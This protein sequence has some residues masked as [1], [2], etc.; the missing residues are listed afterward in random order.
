MAV[1][2][3]MPFAGGLV[4]YYCEHITPFEAQV[5]KR[6]C[7][8]QRYC[9]LT[10]IFKFISRLGDGPLWGALAVVLLVADLQAY[11][12][13][14]AAMALAIGLSVVIFMSVKNLVGRPRPFEAWDSLPCI[15]NPPDRFSFPSG[16]TMTAFAVVGVWVVLI[17]GYW[18]VLLPVAML[19]GLSRIY[20]G[21]H[22]PT[23]VLFG[24]LLGTTIG[25]FTARLFSICML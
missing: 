14:V 22:Y 18:F 5:M 10:A 7:V 2:R 21:V 3:K 6:F 11:K 1:S 25:M 23:D 19:I 9:W 20:L 8:L 16:H 24:A 13:V 17:P 12:W 15:M 4:D